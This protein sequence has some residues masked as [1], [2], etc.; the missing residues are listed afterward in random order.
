MI[1]VHPEKLE[2]LVVEPLE[3]QEQMERQMVEVEEHNR[4]AVLDLQLAEE[5]D[6]HYK[7]ERVAQLTVIGW[8]EAVVE[9]I[10]VEVDPVML[11]AQAELAEVEVDLV[12][13]QVHQLL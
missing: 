8:E 13:L 4:Q 1:T 9:V 6:P 12:M 10:M 2:V 5:V 3:P 7:E 11:Q